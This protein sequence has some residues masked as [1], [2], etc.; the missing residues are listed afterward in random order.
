MILIHGFHFINKRIMKNLVISFS[1]GRTSAFMTK[2]ILEHKKYEDYNKI[3]VFANTGKEKEETLQFVR[4]CDK[5][6]NFKTVW[7]EADVIHEKRKGTDFKLIDFETASRNGEPFEEVIKKYGL[8]TVIGSHCTRELKL[9]P[10]SKYIKSLKLKGEVYT[11][12]GIRFDEMQRMSNT[13]NEKKLIYDISLL[14]VRLICRGV[15]FHFQNT[16]H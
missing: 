5:Y 15:E 3:I 8:P 14:H 16:S 7:V 9:A 11:A 10:I 13:A 12:I 1:G 2:F 4:D 6:F